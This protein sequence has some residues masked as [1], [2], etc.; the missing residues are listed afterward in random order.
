M[1]IVGGYEILNKM[2]ADE[3][4]K[5]KYYYELLNKTLTNDSI[6]LSII[7]SM[8]LSFPTDYNRWLVV[9]GFFDINRQKQILQSFVTTLKANIEIA[10]IRDGEKPPKACYD[11]LRI[12]EIHLQTIIATENTLNTDNLRCTIET[13]SELFSVDEWSKYV[14]ALTQ[15]NPP[16]LQKE[17]DKTYKFIGNKNKQNGC[18]GQWF[19]YLKCHENVIKHVS[20]HVIAKVLS[21]EIQDFEIRASTVDTETNIYKDKYEEQL[22]KL[23]KT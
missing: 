9:I 20:K 11:A 5:V 22:K 12:Y 16:L 17:A 3:E 13:F 10:E 6:E 15:C 14:D 1:G 7:E 19:N 21:S 2:K 18:V 8:E 23:I 4:K